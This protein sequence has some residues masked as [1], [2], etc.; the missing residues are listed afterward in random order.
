MAEEKPRCEMT[1]ES[2]APLEGEEEQAAPEPAPGRPALDRARIL[3]ADDL[4]IERVE[5][6]EWGGSVCVRTLTGAE[7]DRFEGEILRR[8][9]G[10]IQGLKA[11]LVILTA[12]DEE[13]QPLFEKVDVEAV[14][15]KNAR[16]LER[17]C[18]VAQKLNGL[19]EADVAELAGNSSSGPS[20]GSGSV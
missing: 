15:G 6:P 11:L 8:S 12:C 10:D 16:A 20:E 14:R 7:R 3:S 9:E 4:A 2:Q 19:T 1:R 13:G 17:V 5:V 18:E